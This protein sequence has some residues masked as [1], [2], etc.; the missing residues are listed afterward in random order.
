VREILSGSNAAWLEDVIINGDKSVTREWNNVLDSAALPANRT[1]EDVG[2]LTAVEQ[3]AMAKQ[4]QVDALVEAYRELGHLYAHINPLGSYMPPNLRYAWITQHGIGKE[5]D[6]ATY[7]LTDADLDDV[8]SAP[9]SFD[10]PRATLREI[11][12]RLDRVYAGSMGSEFLHIRNRSM[13]R[14][15]ISQLES[16]DRLKPWSSDEMRRWQRDLIRAEEFES[17]VHSRFTGQKR[18]SLEGTDV[19]IPALRYLF[20][21][22]GRR[23]IKDIVIGMAHRGRLN[24]LTNAMRKPASEIF[25]MF[26]GNYVPH[27]YGGSGD[28]KYHLGQSMDFE[29]GDGRTVHIS[30]VSNPSH[31]EA[32]DPVVQGK[33]RGTQRLKKDVTRKKVLPVLIHGD[34]SFS[35]QGIVAETFNMSQLR[36]YR[37][38][39]T[40]HIVVN[41]QIGFTTASSDSRSTFFATD[42]AKVMPVPVFH[43]NGDDPEAVIRAIELALRWRQKFGQDVVVDIIG[44]R[45]LGHNEADE[46]SFTHPIMYDL[47]RKHDSVSKIYGRILNERAVFPEKEQED[48]RRRYLDELNEARAAAKKL[49]DFHGFQTL[50]GDWAKVKRGYSFDFPET[51]VP[52]KVLKAVAGK[53]LETPADFK[54]HPKLERFV[55]NRRKVVE[56]GEGVDWSFAESLAFGSLLAEGQSVR[57]SGEDC[58]RGTF[59]QRHAVWWDVSTETPRQHTPLE[60]L[61]TGSARFSVY[62]SPLS[63]FSILGFEYGYSIAIPEILVLW[64]AQFGD[65]ANGAQVIIDQFVSAGESKWARHSGMVMLLP[66]AY[67][68][69]GPEHS[70]AYLE[71]YLSLCAEDN[72]QVANLTT[73]AQYFHILRKQQHQNFRKPLVLMAPKSLLRHPEARSSL[74]ELTSGRFM[75]VLDDPDS[76]EVI[77]NLI[78]CSGHLWYDLTAR[79]RELIADDPESIVARTRIIRLEQLFPF[80]D[81]SLATLINESSGVSRYVWAQE[82]PANRGAWTFVTSRLTEITGEAWLYAGRPASAS[83]ATGSHGKHEEERENLITLALGINS[84]E[85]KNEG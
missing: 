41:N 45:R 60:S 4:H 59:S 54:M 17:Y 77:E 52:E 58:G 62:D 80:P 5:L 71:R 51:G 1:N 34:A 16:R 46:P 28:V 61:A 15:L 73:P 13:R 50:T 23:N 12:K 83:P 35:G 75:T 30:L 67:E 22:S 26:D 70:N 31:L 47:I 33:A 43:A 44:Y 53:L 48:F 21:E 7:G 76:P 25:A 20:T 68:G 38:G 32:A 82:E 63:E 85:G 40:I 79:R 69:Q 57:L 64:E 3:S 14:W 24:V 84:M 27:T 56:S 72:M 74:S 18:F 55:K 36:G 19:L 65:F 66:H 6:P 2:V 10:P 9:V 81:E 49:T 78:V 39:G 8:F 42:I 37:T 29:I 11:I